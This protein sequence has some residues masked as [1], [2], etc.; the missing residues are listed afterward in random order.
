MRSEEES[1]NFPNFILANAYICDAA[2]FG[3]NV[4]IAALGV[5]TAI[6]STLPG[7]F[8]SLAC[9]GTI[10]HQG[11]EPIE[12]EMCLRILKNE[13]A[14]GL[15]KV[16]FVPT[17][18]IPGMFVVTFSSPINLPQP[19]L[20]TICYRVVGMKNWTICGNFNLLPPPPKP[21]NETMQKLQKLRTDPD[22]IE[23]Y[24]RFVADYLNK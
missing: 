11:H 8:T 9:F 3:K 7:K 13:K 16:R 21:L 1:G 22:F 17:G 14:Y 23:A 5:T 2:T 18:P 12:V 24:R 4:G 10:V 20:Y 19:G 15:T 6:V